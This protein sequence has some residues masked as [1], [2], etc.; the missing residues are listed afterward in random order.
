MSLRR[1][2]PSVVKARPLAAALPLVTALVLLAG[3]GSGSGGNDVDPATALKTAAQKLADTSGVTLALTTS[4]LPDGVQGIKGASGTVTDAPAFD[5]TL[6]VVISAGT[7]SVPVKSVDGKVYAK[8]PLTPAF[9][10]INPSD[11]GAPDPG[12]LT[13]AD[14]GIPAILT[15]TTDP[16]SGH[17]IRGGTDNKEVLSTYTGT[18]PATAVGN[19]IPGATGDFQATY[20]IADN[21]ELRQATL[22]GAF[23]GG[24]SMSYTLVLTDYGT[25]TDIA[26]P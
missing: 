17:Q 10:E 13:S 16:Q 18:V 7:F 21:G 24:S 22:T 19:L 11:Y 8:I 1:T 6:T 23:Y 2:P 12:L 4:D 25:S 15:A 20:G 9:A 3:C 5:G 26:A 14:K